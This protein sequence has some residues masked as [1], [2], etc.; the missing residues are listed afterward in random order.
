[1]VLFFL[2][3]CLHW[4]PEIDLDI[5][6]KLQ[7]CGGFIVIDN[8]ALHKNFISFQILRLHAVLHDLSGFVYEYSEKGPSYS[9]FL[10]CPLINE[11]PLSCGWNCFC[12]YVKSFKKSIFNLLE[13]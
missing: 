1:M 4:Y 6:L 8:S 7:P 12:L 5:A 2:A 3:T 10:P 9:Y 11:D 13:C